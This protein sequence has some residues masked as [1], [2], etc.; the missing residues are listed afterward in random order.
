MD[1]KFQGIACNKKQ[2]MQQQKACEEFP[3]LRNA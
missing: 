1:C 3:I 2:N